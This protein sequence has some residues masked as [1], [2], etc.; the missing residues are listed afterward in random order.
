[1]P[2]LYENSTMKLD[3]IEYANGLK[4][5]LQYYLFPSVS[6]FIKATISFSS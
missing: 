3:Y 4:L 5:L 1:M 2:L 6:V